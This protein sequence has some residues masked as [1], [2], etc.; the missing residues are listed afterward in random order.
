[1][2]LAFAL[3][4]LLVAGVGTGAGWRAVSTAR[5]MSSR[6]LREMDSAIDQIVT[7]YKERR[8]I[9]VATTGVVALEERKNLPLAET[10]APA[11]LRPVTAPKPAHQELKQEAKTVSASQAKSQRPRAGRTTARNNALIPQAFIS[12]QK[13][14]TS[15]FGFR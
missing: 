12:L 2:R 8:E 4:C 7:D 6:Q 3:L 13:F 1:M 15:A 11:D 10:P 9:A 5:E 14:A